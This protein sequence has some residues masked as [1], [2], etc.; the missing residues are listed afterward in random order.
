MKKTVEQWSVEKLEANFHRINFPDYQREPNIWSRNAK[1][2]L[3]DSMARG[4]DIA[5]IYMYADEHDA[6]DC[7]DGRQRLGAIMSFLGHNPNDGDNG[8]TFRISNEIYN[9]VD[10]HF[11]A[12]VN[13]SF[14]EVQSL[15]TEDQAARTFIDQMMK[16]ELTVVLLSESKMEM[17]FNLQFARLNLGTIINSGEKLHAMVGDLRDTC[18]NRLGQ[19]EFLRETKVPIRRYSKEQLAAQIVAQVFALESSRASGQKEYART[20]HFDLQRLFKQYSSVDP[21]RSEWITQIENVM[22]LLQPKFSET[23]TLRNRAIVVSTVLLAYEENI[24]STEDAR[25][26]AE[27]VIEFGRCLK[28]QIKKGLDV[29]Q[30]YRY[31]VEFQRHLTQASV[32]KPAVEARATAFRNGLSLWKERTILR[33]DKEYEARTQSDPRI[34]RSSQSSA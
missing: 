1:Q 27:F 21:K 4:F 22:N 17:E 33:G 31:L 34:E 24:Q 30:E 13:R 16:Y 32:E 5:S 28:W 12:V 2:R 7:V 26:I 20:R 18:F 8:F 10:N 14:E 25:P 29:D 6:L 9:D 11:N 3:V 23:G 19:H 15:A